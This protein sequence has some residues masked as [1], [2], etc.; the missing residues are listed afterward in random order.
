VALVAGQSIYVTE[1]N[2]VAG[3]TGNI[4]FEYGTGSNCGTG[5]TALTGAYNLTAQNGLAP[6]GGT[7][8]IL[9]VP[10]GNALC[11]LTSANVQMSGSVAYQQF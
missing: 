6:G 7:S 8:T 4:T 3:G 2:V 9:K 5:T 11:A 1:F 10:A